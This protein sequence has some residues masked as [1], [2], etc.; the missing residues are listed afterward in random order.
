MNADTFRVNKEFTEFPEADS[1]DAI[2]DRDNSFT[3]QPLITHGL[4]PSQ[5]N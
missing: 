5:Y 3:Q 2:Q 1:I 4:L